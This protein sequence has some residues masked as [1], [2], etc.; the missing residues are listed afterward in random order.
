MWLLADPMVWWVLGF[1]FVVLA[2]A[3]RIAT[4]G[5]PDNADHRRG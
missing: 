1:T 5:E 4:W 2:I 3:I